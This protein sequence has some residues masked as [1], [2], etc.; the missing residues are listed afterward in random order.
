MPLNS[1]INQLCDILNQNR[2]WYFNILFFLFQ[3]SKQSLVFT[4]Y[5]IRNSFAAIGKKFNYAHTSNNNS[6][7]L[8]LV[9]N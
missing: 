2:E 3:V 1:I 6:F 5:S 9:S 4:R 8:T 7:T